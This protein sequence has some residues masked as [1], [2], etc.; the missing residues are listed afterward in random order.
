MAV[1]AALCFGFYSESW[2][3]A[4]G[5]FFVIQALTPSSRA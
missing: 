2:L 3:V 4:L 1:L 5:V